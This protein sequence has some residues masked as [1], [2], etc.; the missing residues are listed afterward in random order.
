MKRAATLAALLLVGTV[1]SACTVVLPMAERVLTVQPSATAQATA[2]ASAT[3][4]TPPESPTR[5]TPDV[6][7]LGLPNEQLEAL[8][9][10]ILEQDLLAD[11]AGEGP[12]TLLA[13]SD[14]A[15]AAL[16]SAYIHG[17]LADRA[18]LEA[19]VR[20]HVIPG[21]LALADLSDGA[22][23]T[24]SGESLTVAVEAD[25]V[26]IQGARVLQGDIA[27]PF[28]LVH[29]IDRILPET[30]LEAAATVTLEPTPTATIAP[31]QTARS[32][33]TPTMTTEPSA[34]KASRPSPTLAATLEP[35]RTATPAPTQT[36]TPLPAVP[37][38][39][40]PDATAAAEG[41]E[42]L[43]VMSRVASTQ[44]LSQ[45]A[46]LLRLAGLDAVLSKRTDL[47][48]LAP[49]DEA[50]AE[51][52]AAELS[53]LTA[54]ADALRAWLERY[55]IP[56]RLSAA[57]LQRMTAVETLSGEV[58]AIRSRSGLLIIG[59][60]RVLERDVAAANGVIHTVDTV[61]LP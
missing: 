20:R 26:T 41:D 50:F 57:E 37:A 24:L 60:T 43:D 56:S 34:T 10:A 46:E 28:G 27:V 13:P 35:T 33:A 3:R 7:E 40:L 49:T 58:L 61:V 6:S 51:L 38:T 59:G 31:T 21:R 16:D 18:Q 42:T 9:A 23:V 5:A 15:F 55:I 2:V 36:P 54:D 8:G 32:T 45:L 4:T 1:L 22:M 12:L 30:V 14:A 47:T 29:V 48:L 44:G 17:L 11:V 53:G 19:F 52:S 25:G 39:P